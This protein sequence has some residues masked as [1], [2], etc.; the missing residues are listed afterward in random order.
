MESMIPLICKLAHR[1]AMDALEFCVCE[2]ER[3]IDDA[4]RGRDRARRARARA[5]FACTTDGTIVEVSP[6]ARWLTRRSRESIVGRKV[7]ELAPSC[8]RGQRCAMFALA[9]ATGQALESFSR[10]PEADIVTRIQP[11]ADFVL[12]CICR[13]PPERPPRHWHVPALSPVPMMIE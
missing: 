10:T 3:A 2:L 12:V 5:L 7:W 1:G 6:R 11:A 8:D 13:T 4:E 9:A